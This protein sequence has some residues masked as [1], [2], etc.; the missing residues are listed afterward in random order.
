[1]KFCN[2]CGAQAA[3]GDAVCKACGANFG[4]QQNANTGGNA[5]QNPNAQQQYN[6]QYNQAYRFD[7]WDHTAEFA[8]Q[9]IADNKLFAMLCYMGAALVAI[10][11]L[12]Y[13]PGSP[14][15]RFH[16]RQSI[17]ISIAFVLAGLLNIIP[18]LGT[19]AAFIIWAILTV[20]SIIC[21]I[22][23]ASGKSIEA[24]IIRSINFLK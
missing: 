14:Y 4:T 24:P 6:Q 18:I 2:K 17:R 20:V 13:S 21:F 8:A 16:V 12:L 11:A 10:L 15:I 5:T 9:D 3:D 22:N 23:T 7:P 19:I 1:M